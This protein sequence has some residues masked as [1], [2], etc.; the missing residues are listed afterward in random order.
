MPS[1]NEKELQQKIA[2]FLSK[3]FYVEQEVWSSDHKC[4]IDIVLVHRSDVKK[5][6]P[7]GIEIK[8]DDKKTG[9]SLGQWLQQANNYTHQIFN[10]YGQLMIITFPQISGKCLEEGELMSKH[11]IWSHDCMGCHHNV[12]TFLGQFHIGELQKYKYRDEKT[13]LR[14]TYNSKS[15]WDNRTN[16]FK[17]Q[18][19]LFGCR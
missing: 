2:T 8:T 7:I 15:V 6:Y 11:D 1:V 17:E 9:S 19:Y 10:G 4:R 5:E 13:Y 12:N 14:I 16:E 3:Y 18:N